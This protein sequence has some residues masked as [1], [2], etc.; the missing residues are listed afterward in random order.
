[1]NFIFVILQFLIILV[2]T[3]TILFFSVIFTITIVEDSNRVNILNFQIS[4][5]NLGLLIFIIFI[6]S[7][8][9][10]LKSKDNKFKKAFFKLYFFFT[11]VVLL[12]IINY[13]VRCLYIMSLMTVQYIDN[14]SEINIFFYPR[15]LKHWSFNEKLQYCHNFF[16]EKHILI[17]QINQDILVNLI[18][19]SITIKELKIGLDLLVDRHLNPTWYDFFMNTFTYIESLVMNNTMPI[20]YTLFLGYL[21][22][23][24]PFITY[25]IAKFFNIFIYF[26][27]FESKS[28]SLILVENLFFDFDILETIFDLILNFLLYFF[29]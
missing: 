11:Q 3:L 18:N 17:K 26:F 2:L 16:L 13:L 4:L 25:N 29:F 12:L 23:N 10:N 5:I 28:E 22:A 27:G 14:S 21:W 20:I 6:L 1:M 8:I 24:R 19:K 9:L 7:S 15:L